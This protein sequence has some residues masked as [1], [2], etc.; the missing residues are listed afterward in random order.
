MEEQGWER[1][2]MG[3]EIGAGSFGTVYRADV[4][5]REFAVKQISVPQNHEE[6]LLNE[7]RIQKKF[8]NHPNIVL[9]CNI[10]S[11]FR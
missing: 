3:A 11:P 1:L 7:V 9:F 4:D 8:D 5:G 10:H 6:Y 2:V